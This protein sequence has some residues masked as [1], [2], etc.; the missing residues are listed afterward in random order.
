MLLISVAPLWTDKS[1]Y[2]LIHTSVANFHFHIF[3]SFFFSFTI[4]LDKLNRRLKQIYEQID[5]FKHM[6]HT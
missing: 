4:F 2:T 1:S 3:L 5:I 6:M